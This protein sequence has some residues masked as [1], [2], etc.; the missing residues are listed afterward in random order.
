MTIPP[1]GP[2]NDEEPSR[3]ISELVIDFWTWFYAMWNRAGEPYERR[4]WIRFD[5]ITHRLFK[6]VRIER[7]SYVRD[8]DEEEIKKKRG[9]HGEKENAD[10]AQDS[11]ARRKHDPGR[12]RDR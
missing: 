11:R 5:N 9:L 7:R 6:R 1:N 4:D 10:D 12:K 8:V 3:T 2:K